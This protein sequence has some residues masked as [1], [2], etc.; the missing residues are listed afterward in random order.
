MQGSEP[1]NT[2]QLSAAAVAASGAALIHAGSA[3]VY[4]DHPSVAR[5]C[6]VVALFEAAWAAAAAL[7]PTRAAAALG[8]V[9]GLGVAGAT[10]LTASSGLASV[11]SADDATLGGAQLVAALL[12]AMVGILCGRTLLLPRS[13][14]GSTNVRR[15]LGV[16]CGLVAVG[17]LVMILGQDPTSARVEEHEHD[18]ATGFIAPFDPA[19]PLDLSTVPGVTPEHQRVAARLV[20]ATRPVSERLATTEAAEAAGFVSAGDGA[21]GYEHVV[22]AGHVVDDA[23]LDPVQPE[24]LGYEVGPGGR[25]SL[26]FVEYALVPGTGLDEAPEVGGPLTPWEERSDLCLSLPTEAA[27]VD[28][29]RFEGFVGAD[30]RCGAGAAPAGPVPVLKVW[31]VANPCGPFASLEDTRAAAADDGAP[32]CG[33]GH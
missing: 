9:L 10:L 29:R 31:V 16:G 3:R 2:V 33:R 30:G 13:D 24:I 8:V 20:D 23:D 6:L 25:R 12:A 18:R 32:T 19:G 4:L 15:V 14:Q 27:G 1:S 7:V 17:G 28:A 5:L 26:A 21:S 22:H 11:T